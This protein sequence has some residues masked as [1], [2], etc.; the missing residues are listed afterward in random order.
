MKAGKVKYIDRMCLSLGS[1]LYMYKVESH[2]TN[3]GGC[4]IN[5]VIY[6]IVCTQ[7]DLR[8]KNIIS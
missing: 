6:I 3:F 2:N 8:I 4:K 5:E 1:E 7:T